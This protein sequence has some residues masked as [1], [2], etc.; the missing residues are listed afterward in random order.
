MPREPVLRWQAAFREPAARRAQRSSMPLV[1]RPVAGEFP[2]ALRLPTPRARSV[3]A[4]P[5]VRAEVPPVVFRVV[6]QFIRQPVW[7]L[8]QAFPRVSWSM[9]PRWPRHPRSRCRSLPL[10]WSTVQQ[11]HPRPL[12]R[13]WSA[14]AKVRPPRQQSVV[15]TP[16]VPVAALVVVAR[17]VAALAVERLVAAVVRPAAVPVVVRPAAVPVVVLQAVAQALAVVVRPVVV[18][19]VVTPVAVQLVVA[20]PVVVVSAVQVLS[21]LPESSR[22]VG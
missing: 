12:S 14:A 17:R 4:E 21:P 19:L 1:R 7:R 10:R 5:L 20:P 6:P 16:V 13:R 3:V 11:P 15:L 2:V 8:R 22:A 18:Q 9:P